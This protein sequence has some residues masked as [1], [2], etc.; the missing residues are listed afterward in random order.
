VGRRAKHWPHVEESQR[1]QVP[2]Q[3]LIDSGL[4]G[5]VEMAQRPGLG[6]AREPQ[7]RYQ[8]AFLG[9]GHLDLQQPLQRRGHRQ[10]F[11]PGRIQDP[12]QMFGGVTEFRVRQVRP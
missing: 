2:N 1:G 6:Q 10:I 5:E 4:G 12:G 8:A 7:P 11:R 9:G 3:F